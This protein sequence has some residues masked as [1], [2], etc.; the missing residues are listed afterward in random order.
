MV[1]IT[2]YTSETYAGGCCYQL[3]SANSFY[4]DTICEMLHYSSNLGLETYLMG[5]FNIDWFSQNTH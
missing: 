5:D 2:H 3:P 1:T 4:L